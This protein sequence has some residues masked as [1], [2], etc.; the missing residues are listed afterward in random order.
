MDGQS[1]EEQN[2][3]QP[4]VG[5][6]PGKAKCIDCQTHAAGPGGALVFTETEAVAAGQDRQP[7]EV[8]PTIAERNP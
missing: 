3:A 4:V 8:T 5:G 1:G 7:A 2:V 6:V